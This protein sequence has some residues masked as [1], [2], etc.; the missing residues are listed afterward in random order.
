MLAS[1][2]LRDIA[3]KT[4]RRIAVEELVEVVA[5]EANSEKG[6]RRAQGDRAR[7]RLT[8]DG[9]ARS[10]TCRRGRGSWPT[11]RDV[12]RFADRRPLCVLDR[13]RAPERLIRGVGPRLE[14]SWG[15]SV[16][17]ASM[18]VDID[19]LGYTRATLELFDDGTVPLS[20][21]VRRC[22]RLAHL[23]G[24]WKSVTWLELEQHEFG[25]EKPRD[26]G[27]AADLLRAL[28]RDPGD[29]ERTAIVEQFISR[30]TYDSK[31]SADNAGHVSGHSVE[32][33][34]RHVQLFDREIASS[35]AEVGG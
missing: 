11:S 18:A 34:E 10:R 30:R 17:G 23:R 19:E 29:A 27:L 33:L 21:V 14:T 24:D 20:T 2:C 6:H 4:C 3:G 12:A 16:Y 8:P 25:G 13:D 26:S 32:L 9:P 1:M 31:A 22:L 7:P 15:L 35:A 5:V 28:G